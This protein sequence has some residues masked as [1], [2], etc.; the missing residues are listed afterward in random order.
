MCPASVGECILSYLA[1]G[2]KKPGV[3]GTCL[4]EAEHVGAPVGVHTRVTV[5]MLR[6]CD[7]GSMP[8][9][10]AVV[11]YAQLCRSLALRPPATRS[12]PA[13]RYVNTAFNVAN[14][15]GNA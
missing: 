14:L 11:H 8:L 15:N 4:K 13:H 12:P 7:E 9:V 6:W 10:A 3:D 1:D 2:D 5:G